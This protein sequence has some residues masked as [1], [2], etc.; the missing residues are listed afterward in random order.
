MDVPAP[1]EVLPTRYR[2]IL[3]GVAVL[4][5]RGLRRAAGRIRREAT[6]AY[7]RA[8]DARALRRLDRLI[9]E[10][11]RLVTGPAT[12]TEPGKRGALEG[13]PQTR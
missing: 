4:E 7:S 9:A 10:L 13:S 8:W 6:S 5:S 3:D 12:T 11:D 2:A 1:A